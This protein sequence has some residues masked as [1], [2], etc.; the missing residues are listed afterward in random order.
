MATIANVLRPSFER[1]EKII[2]VLVVW[3]YV[4][5]GF[6]RS[7]V[8]QILQG[9]KVVTNV[10]LQTIQTAL[11]AAGVKMDLHGLDIPQ[12]IRTVCKKTI[13]EPEFHRMPCCPKCFNLY[14]KN[15]DKARPMHCTWRASPRSD[16]CSERL[17]TVR[18]KRSGGG[19]YVVRAQSHYTR[20]SFDE[21]LEFFLSRKTIDDG[22]RET[23]I[24]MARGAPPAGSDLCDIQ[25]SPNFFGMYNEWNSPY[26][27]VFS[28]YAD[29]FL[30]H[31]RKIAGTL[32]S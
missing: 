31:K 30:V 27:L 11:R 32:D 25:D 6:S 9:I 12:D 16:M 24:R 18:N 2:S 28:I 3:L 7:S 14:P 13:K 23:H 22:I 20:Q 1:V 19:A 15:P 5:G 29:W 26:K 21:W 17:W 4:K 10:L 8:N